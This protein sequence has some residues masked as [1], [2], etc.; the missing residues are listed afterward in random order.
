MNIPDNYYKL[1]IGEIINNNDL[2]YRKKNG[3]YQWTKTVRK[4]DKVE[5]GDFHYI[6]LNFVCG[7]GRQ[8]QLDR[9]STIS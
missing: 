1:P 5:K 2:V 6:R 8:I 3:R 4:G 9:L 7:C